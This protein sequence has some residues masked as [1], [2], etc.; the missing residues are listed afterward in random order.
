MEIISQISNEEGLPV[1]DTNPEATKGK[2]DTFDLSRWKSHSFMWEEIPEAKLKE[3][4]WEN[5][6]NS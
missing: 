5:I 1:Q 4:D 3:L 6:Y 2:M